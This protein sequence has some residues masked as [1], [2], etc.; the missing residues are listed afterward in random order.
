MNGAS[1]AAQDPTQQQVKP[2]NNPDTLPSTDDPCGPCPGC[3]RVSNFMVTTYQGRDRLPY[4]GGRNR[5][6]VLTCVCGA[7]TLVIEAEADDG[8]LTPIFWWPTPGAGQLDPAVPVEVARA[9]DEGVRILAIGIPRM[10]VGSFRLMLAYVF[11]EFLPEDGKL[12]KLTIG[13][14][15]RHLR[16][17]GLIPVALDEWAGSIIAFGNAGVHANA[18][19][20]DEPSQADGEQVQQLCRHLIKSLY[21]IPAQI[22]RDAARAAVP[23]QQGT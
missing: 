8:T 15:L 10:A 20:L 5:P 13:L 6:A 23:R 17:K 2:L 4:V 3:G 21:E 7:G 12:D 1:M 19:D 11:E 9:Y 14:Q 16:E 22:K 18:R